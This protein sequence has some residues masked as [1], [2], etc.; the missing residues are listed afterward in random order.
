[1]L[2]KTTLTRQT[3]ETIVHLREK[4]FS[5]THIAKVTG[6]PR[7]TVIRVIQW[8]KNEKRLDVRPKSGRPRKTST[9]TDRLLQRIVRFQARDSARALLHRWGA[10]VSLTTLRRRL[11]ELGF[12]NRIARRKPV[13]SDRNKAQRLAFC[14]KYKDWSVEDWG[15]VLFT[16]ETKVEISP[17][18]A[19]W[20][21][22]GEE[23]LSAHVAGTK[24]WGISVMIW[25]S[26]TS[27][28]PGPFCFIREQKAALNA[29]GYLDILKEHVHPLFQLES[30]SRPTVYQ[31]DNAPCHKARVV[32]FLLAY[33]TTA[34]SR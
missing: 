34:F 25:G 15:K 24:R 23:L 11:Q 13:L 27:Q 20:R 12:R 14:L 8:W 6:R 26:M 18:R 10:A 19:V 17:P 30:L 4:V 9:R 29:V 3:R 1:M 32:S 21:K 2:R 22:A 31:H 28:G 33:N 5:F 7:S 16:D